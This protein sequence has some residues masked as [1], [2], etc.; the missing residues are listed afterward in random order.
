VAHLAGQI[1]AITTFVNHVFYK[2]LGPT[3]RGQYQGGTFGDHP[4]GLLQRDNHLGDREQLQMLD[5][6]FF[7]GLSD[8]YMDADGY[9]SVINPTRIGESRL[10]H[11]D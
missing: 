6:R 7:V 3:Q 2:R 9:P 4:A 1:G 10:R 11:E 5:I 8:G